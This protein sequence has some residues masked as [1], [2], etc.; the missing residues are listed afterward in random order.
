MYLELWL[1]FMAF[2]H[3][4]ELKNYVNKLGMLNSVDQYPTIRCDFVVSK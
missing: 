4:N 2:N 1:V 3:Q